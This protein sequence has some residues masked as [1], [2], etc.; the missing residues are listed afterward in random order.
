[1]RAHECHHC[2]QWIAEG[3]A[4]DCW[5]TT[6]AAL[7]QDLSE[8]LKDAWERLRPAS[9]SPDYFVSVTV[10]TSTPPPVNLR[11]L[12]MVSDVVVA[13]PVKSMRLTSGSGTFVMLPV[14]CPAGVT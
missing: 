5:T 14:I 3:E 1:M 13:V 12:V 4:H 11:V 2:K 7:T 6:E 9:G 8:E 10:S